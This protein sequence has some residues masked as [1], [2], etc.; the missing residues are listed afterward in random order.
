MAGDVR[1]EFEGLEMRQ[2]ALLSAFKIELVFLQGLEESGE[3]GRIESLLLVDRDALS[4]V[5]PLDAADGKRW[6]A[7]HDHQRNDAQ[8]S[9]Q[10]TC[11]FVEAIAIGPAH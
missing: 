8:A 2:Q 3:L 1:I 9:A 11:D 7:V 4:H 6:L 10:G 5:E